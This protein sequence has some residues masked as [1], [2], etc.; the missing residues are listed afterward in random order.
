[1]QP[2]HFLGPWT[3]VSGSKLRKVRVSK[4]VLQGDTKLQVVK[5][6]AVIFFM[7]YTLHTTLKFLINVRCMF[8]DFKVFLP[9]VRSYMENGTEIEF[10]SMISKTKIIVYFC[11]NWT[12]WINWVCLFRPLRPFFFQKLPPRTFIGHLV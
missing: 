11:R 10:E 8:I 3:L 1:M 7:I 9:P 5:I 12:L 2:C 4:N 6:W